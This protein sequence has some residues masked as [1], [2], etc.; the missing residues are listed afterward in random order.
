MRAAAEAEDATE[1]SVV[2]PGPLAPAR[3]LYG[4]MLLAGAMPAPALAAFESTLAKEPNRLMPLRGLPRRPSRSATR[5]K[6]STTTKNWWRSPAAPMS[7]DRN[8]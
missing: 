5:R 6:P 7:I 1:K 3:E 4:A 8:S 2:T